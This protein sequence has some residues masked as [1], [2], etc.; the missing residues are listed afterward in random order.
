MVREQQSVGNVFVALRRHRVLAED[1]A[2]PAER[3]Q[4]LVDHALLGIGLVVNGPDLETD[5]N[6]L[7]LAF[8]P[9]KPSL[10]QFLPVGCLPNAL[11]QKIFCK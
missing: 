3:A 10:I 1:Q 6:F 11:T 2:V 4:N 8:C 5:E 9:F 7:Q